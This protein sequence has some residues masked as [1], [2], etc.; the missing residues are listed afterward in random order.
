MATRV[1][2]GV[3]YTIRE[4]MN[5]LGQ[6]FVVVAD[7]APEDMATLGAPE[8]IQTY[9]MCQDVLYMYN[10][11]A[12]VKFYGTGD[13]GPAGPP[14]T[15]SIGTVASLAAGTS[16]TASIS[17]TAPNQTLSLGI[18]RGSNGTAGT[19]G[20]NGVNGP[21]NSLAIG[22]VTGLSAGATPTATITGTAPSQ[23]LNL[24]IPAGMA[25]TNGT[26]GSNG[27]ANTLSIGTVTT[28]SA[29]A[30]ATAS[31]SGSAPNQTLSLGIP[32]GQAGT[33]GTNGTNGT[34]GVGIAPGAPAA[35]TVAFATAYQASDNTKAAHINVMLES[36]YLTTLA[37]TS[38]DEVEIRIGS[39]NAV[40]TG[41]GNQVATWKTSLTGIALT[42]GLGIIQR[43]PVAF[44]LPAG[45]YFAVR[46]VS[47]TTAT[48]QST[49]AQPLG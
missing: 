37:G 15:L 43:S 25:G 11:T 16:A 42:V 46:R 13:P 20:T 39:T 48:I 36:S 38:A 19:N 3:T 29:G 2:G 40:A 41:G 1:I 28:L 33:S 12:W 8:S 5:Y 18:P 26:N 34:N 31:V 6:Q 47:G 4:V 24:G 14:N 21:A 23:T 9:A 49:L 45:W 22:S 32:Q 27:P 44:M 30:S 35:L 17:G 10:G 7:I